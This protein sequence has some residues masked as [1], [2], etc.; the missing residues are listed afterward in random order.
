MSQ[1]KIQM[2]INCLMRA[3]SNVGKALE[4][5]RQTDT[6]DGDQ[7]LFSDMCDLRGKAN[8]IEDYMWQQEI[9]LRNKLK[10]GDENG[11]ADSTQ[12]PN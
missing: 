7:V 12:Q 5:L 8:E 11:E 6:P 3:R 2:D 4:L 1:A 10:E 9:K